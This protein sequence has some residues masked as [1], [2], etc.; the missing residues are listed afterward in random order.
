MASGEYCH[1]SDDWNSTKKLTLGEFQCLKQSRKTIYK[2]QLK[3][4]TIGSM[5]SNK[6]GPKGMSKKIKDLNVL[7][8]VEKK[9][10]HNSEEIAKD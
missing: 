8:F 2:W 6:N 3:L 5:E 9:A 4:R 10:D 1:Q 7:K